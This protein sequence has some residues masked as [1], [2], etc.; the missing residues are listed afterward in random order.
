VFVVPRRRGDV[1]IAGLWTVTAGWSAAAR[2][3][4]GDA[5]VVTPD[6]VFTPD[7]VLTFAAPPRSST[8]PPAGGARLRHTPTIVRTAAKDVLRARSARQFRDAGADA[9]WPSDGLA[10]VWQYHDLF[11]SAGAPVARRAQCPLV[12]FVDAPQVWEARRWGVA[13]PGWGGLLERFGE[14]PS[15]LAS[16]VVACVS[17]EVATQ[18]RRLGVDPTRIVVSPTAVDARFAD[19]TTDARAELGLDDE[20]VVGWAGTFRRFQGIDVVVDAFATLHGSVPTA[21]LLLVGDGAER[22]HVEALVTAAGLR[23]VTR[24]TGA[25]APRDVPRYLRAM[26]VAVASARPGEG[27]HY[28][29]L[30]LREYLACGRAVAAPRVADVDAFLTDG[31]HALLYEAGSA[32]QLAAALGALADDHDLRARLGAG[33]RALVLATATWDVRLDALLASDAFQS[34]KPRKA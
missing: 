10:F 4:F 32:S 5:S 8:G 14:R 12:T 9:H 25:V 20:F 18:V 6:G 29:P 26:D 19:E 15:L 11:H 33:G 22:A 21:R 30:K 17:D 1:T 23:H 2:R 3:R 28:S 31:E 13:R 24:F 16:D 27:F 34:V 7:D